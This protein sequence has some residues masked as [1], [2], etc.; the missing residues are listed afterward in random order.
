[1]LTPRG[2]TLG[3]GTAEAVSA[4]PA[5]QCAWLLRQVIRAE[6]LVMVAGSGVG[7]SVWVHMHAYEQCAKQCRKATANAHQSCWLQCGWYAPKQTVLRYTC[8]DQPPGSTQHN[9][10]CL[11]CR[12]TALPQ[13]PLVLLAAQML[14]STNRVGCATPLCSTAP[15]YE[16]LPHPPSPSNPAQLLAQARFSAVQLPPPSRPQPSAVQISGL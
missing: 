6:A 14:T 13:M 7:G 4:P 16:S 10:P 9:I 8:T 3:G 2:A 12:L 1:M 5:E 15:P 11:R